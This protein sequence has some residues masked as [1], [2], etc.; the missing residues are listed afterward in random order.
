M[1]HYIQLDF[2][3]IIPTSHQCTVKETF[4]K[5]AHFTLNPMAE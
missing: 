4:Q 1:E 2:L 3:Q 5:N